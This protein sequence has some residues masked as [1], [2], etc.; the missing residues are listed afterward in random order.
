MVLIEAPADEDLSP[1]AA[2]GDIDQPISTQPNQSLESEAPGSP[3]PNDF[4]PKTGAGWLPVAF[5]SVGTFICV[6]AIGWF[7]WHRASRSEPIPV[8]AEVAELLPEEPDESSVV[9]Q[10][11][12]VIE[13]TSTVEEGPQSLSPDA[14]VETDVAMVAAE[15]D[16]FDEIERS[17]PLD[18]TR[19]TPPSNAVSASQHDSPPTATDALSNLANLLGGP[20]SQAPIEET[21]S[22]TPSNQASSTSS[23][24]TRPDARENADRPVREVRFQDIPLIDFLRS[25]TQLTNVPIYVDPAALE[26]TGKVITT[27]VSVVKR[28]ASSL[29]I[30]Q[31]AL[32]PIGM[33]PLVEPHVIRITTRRLQDQQLAQSTLYVGDL[34]TDTQFDWAHF[35][36]T[37]VEPQS[38]TM[39]NGA[40]TIEL[41]EDQLQISNTRRV[42]VRTAIFLER[43]RAARSLPPQ[44]R[45]PSH[46]VSIQP[47]WSRVGK[48]LGARIDL[49]VWNESQLLDVISSLETAADIRI[50]MDWWSLGVRGIYPDTAAKLYVRNTSLEA[51]IHMLA[52]NVDLAIIPIDRQTIQ[53]TTDVKKIDSTYLEFY[54]FERLSET[55]QA[56]VEQ[57]MLQGN[58]AIDPVSGSAIVVGTSDLHRSLS[59]N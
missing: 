10:P 13:T 14:E 7:S 12:Q 26:Q 18:L 37:L 38:W 50:L 59:S 52:G 32:Q 31:A 4:V 29:D 53:I 34:R 49:N 16:P 11:Q 8:P 44:K 47:R 19:I 15:V 43:L 22:T 54:S 51:A 17:K 36:A 46:L 48:K 24:A 20:I 3:Q 9:Q 42:I 56:T 25:M 40:G 21:V 23:L 41:I 27:P 45:I 28:N 35:V 5:A 1:M 6:S 33:Q 57:L 39:R 55:G 58:A 2:N 30:L